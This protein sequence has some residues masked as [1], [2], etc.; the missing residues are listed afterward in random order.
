MEDKDIA[1]R[2]KDTSEECSKALDSWNSNKKD[3]KTREELR[4]AVHDLRKVASRIEIEMAASERDE[5]A[6]KPIPIPAH[7]D[8]RR[9]GGDDNGNGNNK[10]GGN[11]KPRG[12]KNNNKD[13]QPKK[14]A[15]GEE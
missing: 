5:M 7:R 10:G 9:K 4:D 12:P 13:Q 8:A 3:I 15:G 14:A 1:K 11:K 6:Q 2:L